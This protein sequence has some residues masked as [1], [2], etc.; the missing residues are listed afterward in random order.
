MLESGLW[1]MM[2]QRPYDIVPDPEVAPRDIF[3]TSFDSAPLAPEMLDAENTKCS[4][5]AYVRLPN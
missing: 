3:V 4:R 5:K 1:A 2:R